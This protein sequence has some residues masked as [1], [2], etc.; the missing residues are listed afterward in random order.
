MRKISGT[1]I[2][3]TLFNKRNFQQ[4]WL[5]IHKLKEQR[6]RNQI[7]SRWVQTSSDKNIKN[8]SNTKNR[9]DKTIFEMRRLNRSVRTIH[10]QSISHAVPEFL[11][12][13][14]IYNADL[15]Q[16][17]VLIF[18]TSQQ[19]RTWKDIL[20]GISQVTSARAAKN[21]RISRYARLR[22]SDVLLQFLRKKKWRE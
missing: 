10:F 8:V 18:T 13:T 19:R 14:L 21:I 20:F 15:L 16:I 17:S 6:Q 9:S 7:Q 3:R 1:R 11:Y 2:N 22:G 5:M 12:S 4:N